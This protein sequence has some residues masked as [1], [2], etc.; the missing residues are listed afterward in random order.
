VKVSH[1]HPWQISQFVIIARGVARGQN[2]SHLRGKSAIRFA[3][4]ITRSSLPEVRC[5]ALAIQLAGLLNFAGPGKVA[6]PEATFPF[7]E[8]GTAGIRSL[9]FAAHGRLHSLPFPVMAAS[10]NTLH[11]LIRSALERQNIPNISGAFG[12]YRGVAGPLE[13][14]PVLRQSRNRPICTAFISRRGRNTAHSGPSD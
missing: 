12:N 10:Q 4:P 5:V 2:R 1:P 6:T 7:S 13:N 8:P 14:L 11:C 9:R 3:I